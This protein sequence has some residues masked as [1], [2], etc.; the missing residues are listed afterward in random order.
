MNNPN[1]PQSVAITRY[2]MGGDIQTTEETTEEITEET[3]EETGNES[4]A[5]NK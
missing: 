2:N 1:Y 3:E 4:E 5:S